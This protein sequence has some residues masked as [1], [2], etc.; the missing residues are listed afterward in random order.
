MCGRYTLFVDPET[1]EERFDA[2]I[3]GAYRKR[4]NAAPGQR[5]WVITDE[6]PETIQRLEWGLR[7]S[8]ADGDR[9][10]NARA[11]T[12]DEKP[13]FRAAYRRSSEERER[14]LETPAA[15]RCSLER[16]EREL[17]TPAAGRCLVLADGFYEWVDTDSGRQPY[18]I[19][20]EDG[21]PFAMA[22]L[23]ERRE[24]DTDA[25]TT[26]VGLDDFG[27]G[28][29]SGGQNDDE[30]PLETFT[31]VTTRPNDLVADL[32]HRMAVIP[33][34]GTEATWLTDD[35]PQAL[36]GPHPDSGMCAHPVSTRVNDP[37]TDEPSLVEPVEG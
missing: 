17:E 11:E 27:G 14:E 31:I 7:P 21:R 18:W 10:I 29:E 25:D 37:S 30:H 34:A 12:I 20:F 23:W 8:W 5:L 9:V 15:G 24:S 32:H 36:L 13:T 4:Y 3:E 35:H 16:S 28:L 6:R 33:E 1:L 2:R 26:Q 22:G 19:A